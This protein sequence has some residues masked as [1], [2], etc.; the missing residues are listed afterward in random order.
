L[1]IKVKLDEDIYKTGRK[2]TDEELRNVNMEQSDFH[3]EW[4]YKIQESTWRKGYLFSV[5]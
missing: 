3:G 2:I 5:P 4:N 1:K